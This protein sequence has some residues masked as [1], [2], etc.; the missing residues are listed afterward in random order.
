MSLKKEI[1]YRG[2]CIPRGYGLAYKCDYGMIDICYPI[3]LNIVVRLWHEIYY[4]LERGLFKSKHEE[5]VRHWF[6]VGFQEGKKC[7]QLNL[8][9]KVIKE[10]N[11]LYKKYSNK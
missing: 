7:A 3:P 11:A 4:K 8:E 1:K 10:A 5:D 6:E 2:E 9:S